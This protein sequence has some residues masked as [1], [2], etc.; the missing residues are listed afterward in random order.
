MLQRVYLH[1]QWLFYSQTLTLLMHLICTSNFAGSV[2]YVEYFIEA[3]MLR[4]L[5]LLYLWLP[6]CNLASFGSY[7][8]QTRFIVQGRWAHLPLVLGS[9]NATIFALL[10]KS[11]D[12]MH[13]SSLSSLS[14][15]VAVTRL[16]KNTSTLSALPSSRAA[17]SMEKG[18]GA[19]PPGLIWVLPLPPVGFCTDHGRKP[20]FG[21]GASPLN[22]FH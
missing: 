16:P 21:N 9:G 6:S 18:V 14:N 19:I 2:D 11:S 20:A 10:C 15:N 17:A 7:S 13:R 4:Q 1:L 8:I 22:I 5:D 3:D 12:Q